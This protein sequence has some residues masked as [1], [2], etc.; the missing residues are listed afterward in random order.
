M[1]IDIINAIESNLN[2]QKLFKD[3]E[4]VF[5]KTYG[6]LGKIE[7]SNVQLFK[8]SIVRRWMYS[9]LTTET[10]LNPNY[11]INQLAQEKVKGDYA[12]TPHIRIS[13]DEHD[14]LQLKRE[15]IFYSLD[16]HPVLEDLDR[17]IEFA[18]PTI[19]IREGN[20][21]VVDDGETFIET[22]SFRSGY[23]LDYLLEVAQALGLLESMKSIGCTCLAVGETY[24]AFSKLD[25]LDKI[26]KILEYSLQY[27]ATKLNGLGIFLETFDRKKILSYLDN[28][29][30]FGDYIRNIKP[31]ENNIYSM[32]REQ[33][34]QESTDN[35][36]DIAKVS[37][38]IYYKIFFDMYF[39]SIYGYYLGIISPNNAL[40]CVMDKFI[41]EVAEDQNLNDKLRL[42]F[43]CDDI[44]D[45]TPFGQ[46]ILEQ[47]RKD[48][49]DSYY[50]KLRTED[51]PQIMQ[52]IEEE[53]D[54]NNK[55]LDLE[56]DFQDEDELES[57]FYGNRDFIEKHLNK[58]YS[59]LTKEKGLKYE[60]A[61]DHCGNIELF[62]SMYLKCQDNKN[63]K[64]IT[65]DQLDLYLRGFFME[66][67][68][69]SK[70][71]TKKQLVSI[72]KYGDFLHL[73]KFISEDELKNIKKLVKKKDLYIRLFEEQFEQ[74]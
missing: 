31:L 20:K 69:T 1:K 49:K 74:W 36:K 70:T 63:I 71:D 23:Y 4:E 62:L 2:I 60:T 11:L 59:Y 64:L 16:K 50:V 5:E 39:T 26:N 27:S 44:H 73:K 8:D 51:F 17:L 35:V 19:I 24:R 33:L 3:F 53:N 48:F 55:A 61:E 10:Y 58:F 43:Q 41:K 22:L 65:A 34:P 52:L 46:R 68:A 18:N 25:N 7:R 32:V 13:V 12:V 42:I 15:F 47:F 54:G 14:K 56:F 67:V 57:D 72:G 45:L 38:Q 21:F 28:N 66:N 6:K 37:A 29:I 30:N 9:A 40:V